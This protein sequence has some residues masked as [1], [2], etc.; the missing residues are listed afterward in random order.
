MKQKKEKKLRLSKLTIQNLDTVLNPDDQKRVR[1]GEPN[2]TA[3]P[4]CC[5]PSPETG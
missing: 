5:G 4:I 1:G 2:C 3:V